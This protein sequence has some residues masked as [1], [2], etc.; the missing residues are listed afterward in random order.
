[1]DWTDLKEYLQLDNKINVVESTLP[2][3]EHV[4][5]FSRFYVK[6]K[7]GLGLVGAALLHSYVTKNTYTREELDAYKKG[8]SDFA[9]FFR[10]AK[11]EYDEKV[12]E[13]NKTQ[14]KQKK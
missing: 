4:A 14:N 8:I 5:E 1:M 3:M 9:N 10:Q 7:Q 11:Y 2:T 6:E 12:K 13:Q